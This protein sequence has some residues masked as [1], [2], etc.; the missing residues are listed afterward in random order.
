MLSTVNNHNEHNGKTRQVSC[1]SKVDSVMLHLYLEILVKRQV[2]HFYRSKGR[3]CYFMNGN[4]L[5]NLS[6]GDRKGKIKKG[7][8]LTATMKFQKE[9]S[10]PLSPIKKADTSPFSQRQ[11]GT[12]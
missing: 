12:I 1:C 7:I 4:S 9:I 5:I 3:P 8:A 10:K 2:N 6:F 11:P